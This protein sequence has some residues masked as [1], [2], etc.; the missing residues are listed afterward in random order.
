[1]P[2]LRAHLCTYVQEKCSGEHKG[3]QEKAHAGMHICMYA[4]MVEK[5]R[6]ACEDKDVTK[7]VGT[8]K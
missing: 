1:M 8:G 5:G 7:Y 2:L 3:P 4:Y 6:D